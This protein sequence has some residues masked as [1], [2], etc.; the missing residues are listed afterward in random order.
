MRQ[1][2][3]A[4]NKFKAKETEVEVQESSSECILI[5]TAIDNQKGKKEN[6]EIK[7]T[8]I[9]KHSFQE[10]LR[11]IYYCWP[12]S[13][14]HGRSEMAEMIEKNNQH[15][16]KNESFPKLVNGVQRD[17]RRTSVCV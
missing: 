6:I 10:N 1:K 8:K 5:K 15:N 3:L 16:G 13:Q 4:E 12:I 17:N 9:T 14:F 2:M 11:K 7:Q